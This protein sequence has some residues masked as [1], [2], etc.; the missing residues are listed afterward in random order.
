M[1]IDF[2]LTINDRAN[3][4][5]GFNTIITRESPDSTI[6]IL[7]QRTSRSSS[8]HTDNGDGRRTDNSKKFTEKSI[9][10]PDIG[11]CTRI[12][13]CLFYGLMAILRAPRLFILSRAC[14]K[15]VSLYTS[16]T[17]DV[18]SGVSH[19]P[20]VSCS[21]QGVPFLLRGLCHYRGKPPL[22]GNNT[23]VRTIL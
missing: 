5:S 3:G 10:S 15:S 6:K 17:Y 18:I 4:L 21:K 2:V 8:I 13:A 7:L 22:E 16:V 11:P 23:P 14:W 1:S 12:V 20:E 9:S 19:G